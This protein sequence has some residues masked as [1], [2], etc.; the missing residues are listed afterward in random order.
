MQNDR[1]E[2]SA[3]VDPV[4]S[5]ATSP[6]VEPSTYEA[7]WQ[8]GFAAGRE[9]GKAALFVSSV[10]SGCAAAIAGMTV[11]IIVLALAIN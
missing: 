7:G 11:T 1:Q 10:I 4:T 8:S 5:S 3:A 2:S 9:S 6:T